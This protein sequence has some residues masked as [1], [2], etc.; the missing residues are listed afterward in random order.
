MH[1]GNTA[2]AGTLMPMIRALLARWPLKRVVLVADRGLLNLGNLQALQALQGELDALGR[3]VQLQYVLAVPAARYGDF[4]K[5]L[6]KLDAGHDA[7]T[8]WADEMR[9][10]SEHED[11]DEEDGA[12]AGAAAADA[13][14]DDADDAGCG[15]AAPL[16][17]VSPA[18]PRPVAATAASTSAS[19]G[20]Q[21]T[22]DGVAHPAQYDY[23]VIV[24]H[25]PETAQRRSQARRAQLDELIAL[26]QQWSGQLDEQDGGGKRRRG[27]PLSDSGAKARLYHAVKDAALAHVL[28][29]DLRAELFQYS[30][31]EARLDYLNRLD[32]K[33]LL[34]TNTD[35]P[36]AEVVARYK[37]LAD[38]ERGLRALKSDIEIGP[39]Y[40]RLPKRIRA[41][42]LVCFLALVLH[43]VL[44]MRLRAAARPESPMRLLEQLRRIQ[45]QTVQTAD[46]QRLHGLTELGAQQR[47]LFAAVGLPAPTPAQIATPR[48]QEVPPTA[49]PAL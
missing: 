17:A 49:P 6:R 13:A 37:S 14:A 7:S 11:D 29:V 39:V 8:E 22:A 1:P 10:T 46:G 42:A 27:R 45:H 32:G 16:G 36:P 28:K 25:D 5:A 2:E 21:D 26:G 47:E 24:A 38:I 35:A 19:G 43:R 41:H 3:G 23:R 9:W 40:H 33:L 15:G 34:V 18:V 48:L 31:D 4:K 44:R 20:T 12:A 30:I